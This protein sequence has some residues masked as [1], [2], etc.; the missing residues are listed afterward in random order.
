M[1]EE[2]KRLTEV[3]PRW[4]SYFH[5]KGNALGLPV[6]GNFELTTRCNFSCKMCYVHE[7]ENKDELTA[8]EWI[9]LGR[10]AASAGM[11]FLL[12][13]GGEPFIRPDFKE[14]YSGLK[15]LGLLISINTNGSLLDDDMIAFLAKDPP[16]RMNISLY[17]A[18]DETFSDLCGQPS[19]ERVTENIKKLISAGIQVKINSSITPYNACDIEGIYR[20]GD[21]VGVPVKATTYMFPPVRVNGCKYGTAPHRFTPEEA[22]AY[23]LKCQ[24]QYLTPEQLANSYI[25][26]AGDEDECT[27]GIGDKMHCRA[28][29]TAFWVTWDGRMLPCGMFPME[30]YKI[31]E[32]GFMG[33][34]KK[35]R[36]FCS[37][38]RLPAKCSNCKYKT[39]CAAC[40]AACITETG[41]TSEV[42]EYVCKM[43]HML[44]ALKERKYK[45]GETPDE[46]K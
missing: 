29:K 23:M 2:K 44:D 13:T 42:P 3:E 16:L 10:S 1:N 20:F 17:G 19:Y 41:S 40:A 15:K 12:L 7:N 8:E 6:A 30:G 32:H 45:K 21:E 43:T 18:S 5:A 36:E 26:D 11:V 31:S 37:E 4:S 34:W 39:K 25:E 22:A 46:S 24:E 38:M 28:G 27:D 35:V 9:E 33:A 14:I